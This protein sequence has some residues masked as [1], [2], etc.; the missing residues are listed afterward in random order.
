MSEEINQPPVILYNKKISLLASDY[1]SCIAKTAESILELA[2]VV[3]RAKEDL[4]K[5]EYLKFRDAIKADKSKD[6][7]LKKLH[8]IAKKSSRLN[9]VKH[10]LPAA[11]TTIYEL[12]RL[13][14]TEFELARD[15][16]CIKPELTA[17]DLTEFKSKKSNF[18]AILNTDLK[19]S[20]KSAS[21]TTL[22]KILDEIKIICNENKAELKTNYVQPIIQSNVNQDIIDVEPK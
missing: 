17:A 19:I 4:S 6:S 13:S 16:N 8:C 5:G 14:D 10:A 2:N 11:Y 3:Y 15:S 21:N 18:T 7:Y 1:S 22:M 12:T 9:S 20:I